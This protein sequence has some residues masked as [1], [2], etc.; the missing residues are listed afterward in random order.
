MD[1]S[2]DGTVA[3]SIHLVVKSSPSWVLGDLTE[4]QETT[5]TFLVSLGLLWILEGRKGQ[6]KEGTCRAGTST[7]PAY[8][9][10]WFFG[11]SESEGMSGLTYYTFKYLTAREQHCNSFTRNNNTVHRYPALQR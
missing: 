11:A 8:H 9:F 2:H 4:A 3:S 7:M 1:H 6:E 10:L 5:D